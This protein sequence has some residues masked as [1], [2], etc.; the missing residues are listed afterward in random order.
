L[1]CCRILATGTYSVCRRGTERI[2][3]GK[4]EFKQKERGKSSRI[5][6]SDKSGGKR[7]CVVGTGNVSK[8]LQKRIV[9]MEK[10]LEIKE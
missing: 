2:V 8:G 9:Q 1:R 6:K 7:N 10:W 4:R 5:I 3:N